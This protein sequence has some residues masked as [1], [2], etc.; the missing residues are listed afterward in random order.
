MWSSASSAGAGSLPWLRGSN[1]QKIGQQTQ[2]VLPAL[3]RL[4]DLL[5]PVG[6]EDHSDPV[7][8]VCRGKREQGGQLVHRIPFGA[9]WS[10]DPTGS[11][12]IHDQPD[13][14]FAL[15]DVAFDVRTT[16]AGGHVPVDGPDF[17]AGMVRADLVEIHPSAFE[18][19]PVLAGQKVFDRVAGAQLELS[20]TLVNRVQR[21]GALQRR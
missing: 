12:G 10:G 20:Q 13:G 2:G 6:T 3:A 21:H 4:E 9:T 18:H 19:A 11:R 8:V 14:Q 17:I 16:R 15:L 7:M 5:H 1:G